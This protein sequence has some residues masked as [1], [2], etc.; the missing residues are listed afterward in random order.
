MLTERNSTAV[1]PVWIFGTFAAL[2]PGRW[3]PRL[4]TIT[5]KFGDPLDPRQLA[6]Q[7]NGDDQPGW[8]VQALHDAVANIGRAAG[9]P[10]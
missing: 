10:R 3:L 9:E 2:L 1:V 5:V 7:G 6:S 8:I 4:R